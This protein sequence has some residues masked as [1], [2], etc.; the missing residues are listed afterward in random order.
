MG[1]AAVR[2]QAVFALRPST[3]RPYG[4][5]ATGERVFDRPAGES[6]TIRWP[7]GLTG[8]WGNGVQAPD[9]NEYLDPSRPPGQVLTDCAA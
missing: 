8:V 5:A 2:C 3:G 7:N 1:A 4:T 9:G 6:R